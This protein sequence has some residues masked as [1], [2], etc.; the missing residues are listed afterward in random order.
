MQSYARCD[1]KG[2]DSHVMVAQKSGIYT[3]LEL[4]ASGAFMKVENDGGEYVEVA[5]LG[6]SLITNFGSCTRVAD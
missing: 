3:I 5:S 2:C 6:N 1:E 4:P